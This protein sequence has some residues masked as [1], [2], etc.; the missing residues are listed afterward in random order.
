MN[1]KRYLKLLYRQQSYNYHCPQCGAVV[2]R[3]IRIDC[4]QCGSRLMRRVRRTLIGLILAIGLSSCLVQRVE[5]LH[6]RRVDDAL[7]RYYETVWNKQNNLPGERHEARV[8]LR[9]EVRDAR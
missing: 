9:K 7:D 2:R 5:S 8:A 1:A 3:K 6:T 4:P